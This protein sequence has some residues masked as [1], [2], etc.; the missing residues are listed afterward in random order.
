MR[1][2]SKQQYR[3]ATS[4][5]QSVFIPSHQVESSFH[6]FIHGSQSQQSQERST[7]NN[8]QTQPHCANRSQIYQPSVNVINVCFF[9]SFLK[10]PWSSNVD[11]K[12]CSAVRIGVL[13]PTKSSSTTAA[14]PALW[15][16]F[17]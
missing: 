17:P 8:T 3:Q 13:K 9:S 14:P 4:G 16:C 6:R 1:A 7:F 10:K 12:P 11:L 15:K 2:Q 5:M